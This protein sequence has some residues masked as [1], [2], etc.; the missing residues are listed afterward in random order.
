MSYCIQNTLKAL[1]NDIQGT[2]GSLLFYA[3]MSNI[4][5][6]TLHFNNTYFKHLSTTSLFM[7]IGLLIMLFGKKALVNIMSIQLILFNKIDR[8]SIYTYIYIFQLLFY[9]RVSCLKK[10]FVIF[11]SYKLFLL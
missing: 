3:A 4:L 1:Y 2:L 11:F 6:Q 9:F 8:S 5:L 7:S 10:L